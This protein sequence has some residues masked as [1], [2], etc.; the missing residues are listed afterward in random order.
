MMARIGENPLP[1][2]EMILMHY[3]R[4]TDQG[5][6]GRDISALFTLK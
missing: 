2:V 6:C 5:Y 3:Q 1:I 4:L